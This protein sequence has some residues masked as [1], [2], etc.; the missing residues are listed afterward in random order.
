[1][2]MALRREREARRLVQEQL[3]F[4]QSSRGYNPRSRSPTS[5]SPSI[6][7]PPRP[8]IP[9]SISSPTLIP[10]MSPIPTGESPF[11]PVNLQLP[12][13]P[14][15]HV[16]RLDGPNEEFQTVELDNGA[17]TQVPQPPP[18]PVMRI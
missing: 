10:V 2:N 15:V 5:S 16:Q 13:N 12:Q 6:R 3:F 7:T 4:S 14:H 8:S 11:V 17:N 18:S 1:M 9:V